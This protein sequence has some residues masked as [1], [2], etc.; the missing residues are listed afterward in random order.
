MTVRFDVGLFVLAG[1]SHSKEEAWEGSQGLSER[2]QQTSAGFPPPPPQLG[3]PC[4]AHAWVCPEKWGG[5]SCWGVACRVLR[6]GIA[7]VL[8]A[9]V[10]CCWLVRWD[11]ASQQGGMLPDGEVGCCGLARWDAASRQGGML[12]ASEV[13]CC[14]LSRQDDAASW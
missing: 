7:P 12:L 6:A 3:K 9:V 14:Q 1:G 8:I 13:G 11:A 5:L 10:G 4:K 2:I